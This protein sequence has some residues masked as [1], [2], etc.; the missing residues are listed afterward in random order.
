MVLYNDLLFERE[1]N[2]V[3]AKE[4]LTD[5]ER[6]RIE[7]AIIQNFCSSVEKTGDLLKYRENLLGAV[8][9]FKAEEEKLEMKRDKAE[10]LADK[11]EEGIRQY[12]VAK[13]L[14][15]INAGLF[16]L[17]LRNSTGTVVD[18]IEA[19]PSELVTVTIEKRLDKKAA[20]KFAE[21]HPDAVVGFHIEQR[22]NLQI[23]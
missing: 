4:D 13:G 20:K 3:L 16:K 10:R 6:E 23:K 14:D 18:N 22:Q 15:S 11:I 21:E 2:A 8:S 17:S 19:C 1:M 5:E 9:I 12:M 7:S